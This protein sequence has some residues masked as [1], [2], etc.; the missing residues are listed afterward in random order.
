MEGTACRSDDPSTP[1]NAMAF[2]SGRL[3]VMDMVGL[4]LAMNVI[5][6]FV[7]LIAMHTLGDA[8]FALGT[9]GDQ[10]I[11]PDAHTGHDDAHHD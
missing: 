2:A 1:P 7:V 10:W 11:I 4:G 5:G 3:R 9:V 6:V 8:I